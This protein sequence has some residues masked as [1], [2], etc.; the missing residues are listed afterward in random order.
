MYKVNKK[1][2]IN[3]EKKDEPSAASRIKSLRLMS[4]LSR[5][6]FCL[7]HNISENTL[8]A[9]ELDKL[10]LS[11]KQ[12]YK[13][14]EAFHQDGISCS[15]EWVISGEGQF[16]YL[17]KYGK[18]RNQNIELNIFEDLSFIKKNRHNVIV[19]CVEDNAM[20]PYY[21]IGDYLIGLYIDDISSLSGQKCLVKLDDKF[22]PRF[23]FQ[24]DGQFILLP[25]I[26]NEIINQEVV[27][28]PKKPIL[29]KIVVHIS[30]DFYNQSD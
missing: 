3:M 20:E 8:T 2:K 15:E 25:N 23:L 7:K 13:L 18:E 4:G 29:G 22:V 27:V 24:K 16:P 5:R 14:L 30:R 6:D 28:V 1:I 26:T 12:L 19:V 11:Q 9:I 21:K 10:K 17:E